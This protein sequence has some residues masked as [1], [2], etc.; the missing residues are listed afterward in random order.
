MDPALRRSL[1]KLLKRR[2][3]Y[4]D[5]DFEIDQHTGQWIHGE[6]STTWV[7]R[8]EAGQKDCP[9]VHVHLSSPPLIQM[10]SPVIGIQSPPLTVTSL[11]SPVHSGSQLLPSPQSSQYSQSPSLY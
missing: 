9:P 7:R 10:Q 3:G 2:Y 8:K 4:R 1:L 6:S 5:G 11:L